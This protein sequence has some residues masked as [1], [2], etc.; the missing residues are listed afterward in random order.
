MIMKNIKWI[1]FAVALIVIAIVVVSLTGS[2]EVAA[3]AAA[4][5]DTAINT[6]RI[7]Q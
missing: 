3:V 1:C 6:V 7:Y 5:I 4:D 2:K